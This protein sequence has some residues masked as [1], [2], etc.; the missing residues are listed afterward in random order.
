LAQQLKDLSLS[1]LDFSLEVVGFEMA[2]IDLRIGSLDDLPISEDDPADA[3]PEPAAS[4]PLS[5]NGDLWLLD[6]HRVLCGNALDPAAFALLMREE[7]A[8]MAFTN[9]P[10]NVPIEGHASGLGAIHHRAFPMASGEMDSPEF[11][12]FLSQACRNLAAHSVDGALHYVCMDWRHIGELLTAGREAYSELKNVC[13]WD[14]GSPGMGSLYRGQ[15]ELSSSSSTAALG[16]ATMSSSANSAA[17][18]A[19]PGIIPG[20]TPSRVAARRAICRPCIR[21]SSR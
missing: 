14:K 6:R 16:T 12:A 2:E 15:H 21:P 18:A 5:K 11:I 4:P 17:T 10:Y 13:V 20:P 1:G 9:P 8:G 3:L 19:M 7:R